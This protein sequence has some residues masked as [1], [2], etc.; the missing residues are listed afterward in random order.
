MRIS[1]DSSVAV[2]VKD[3]VPKFTGEGAVAAGRTHPD[4][5]RSLTHH[6][7]SGKRFWKCQ[8]FSQHLLYA[9]SGLKL[10][11]ANVRAGGTLESP[12]NSGRRE[13]VI[14]TT[15]RPAMVSVAQHWWYEAGNSGW[16]Y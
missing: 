13:H 7:R 10:F 15:R 11:R 12:R 2:F 6:T 16:D 3:I 4:P 1:R 14:V 9:P 5:P 8:V